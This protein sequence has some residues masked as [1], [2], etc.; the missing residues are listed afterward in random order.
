MV[1][2]LLMMLLLVAS[3][4]GAME[5]FMQK[6]ESAKQICRN[7]CLCKWLLHV[8]V[9]WAKVCALRNF[10]SPA[11]SRFELS[12]VD[13]VKSF[14][15]STYRC[16]DL[17]LSFF[18]LCFVAS[19]FFCSLMCVSL[20][21]QVILLPFSHP[22]GNWMRMK[23]IGRGLYHRHENVSD[24]QSRMDNRNRHQVRSKNLQLPTA[25]CY[26]FWCNIVAV[27]TISTVRTIMIAIKTQIN[28][29][30]EEDQHIS[31]EI[32]WKEQKST[33]TVKYWFAQHKNFVFS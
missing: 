30:A 15:Q 10:R 1:L 29:H 31:Y 7:E 25:V 21:Y 2:P 13:G 32:P 24:C 8:C 33:V 11:R 19:A 16:I 27:A 17:I 22:R 26:S 28:R 18:L 9:Y 3:E 5:K 14:A 23:L 6:C 12:F 4:R 20:C